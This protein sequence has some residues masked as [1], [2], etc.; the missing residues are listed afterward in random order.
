MDVCNPGYLWHIHPARALPFCAG[1]EPDDGRGGGLPLGAAGVAALDCPPA[2]YPV[3]HLGADHGCSAGDGLDLLQA[4][5][6]FV[7]RYHLARITRTVIAA[8]F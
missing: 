4:D 7:C 8:K 5:R 2:G 3:R 1:P 6:T